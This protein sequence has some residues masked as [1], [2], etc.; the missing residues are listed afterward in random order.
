MK[1]DDKVARGLPVVR[2][3]RQ[4]LEN[5]AEDFRVIGGLTRYCF[6]AGMFLARRRSGMVNKNVC[7][8]ASH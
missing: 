3:G 4:H 7:L 8:Q 5:G 2:S 1:Y 6:Y